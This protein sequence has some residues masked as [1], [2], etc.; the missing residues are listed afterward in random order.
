M[1]RRLGRFLALGGA[2][3]GALLIGPIHPAAADVVTPPGACVGSGTWVKAGFS[4]TSTN[5]Q[6]GDVIKVPQADTVKWA[7][8]QKGFALGAVGPRRA[9]DGA[10]EL[11]L[12]IGTATIDSWGKTSVRYANEGEH[13]YDLPSVL[14]G[15]KM[16]LHGFHKENGKL[17]CSGSVYVKVEGSAFK[18]P[19]AWGAVGGL[20]I[21][22]GVLLYAGRPVFKKIYAFEDINPG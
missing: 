8:N 7:G 2:V 5:H 3:V 10:V 18:N 4:E 20:V 17:T 19:L 12:P 6:T 13:K 15:I 9:I 1:G 14:I 22:G 11:D 21:S 16:R